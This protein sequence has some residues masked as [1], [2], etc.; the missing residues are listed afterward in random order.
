MRISYLLE[1]FD[2]AT[3][4]QIT[5]QLRVRKI[6][7]IFEKKQLLID[8]S[9]EIEVD[10]IMSELG[11]IEE[12]PVETIPLE[13]QPNFRVQSPS[14]RQ[15]PSNEHLPAS[16]EATRPMPDSTEN[17]PPGIITLLGGLVGGGFGVFIVIAAF[18]D[19]TFEGS[20][21]IFLP[22]IILGALGIMV[23]SFIEKTINRLRR[24]RPWSSRF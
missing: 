14:R 18:L 13:N 23:G 8:K 12:S 19:P 21:S 7:Y 16:P 17:Q 9:D 15:P 22:A 24:S 11:T 5:R 4:D 1:D 6:P 3:C 2:T 20:I 10:Q